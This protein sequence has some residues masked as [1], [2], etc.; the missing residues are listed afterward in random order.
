MT[1]PFVRYRYRG[2]REREAVWCDEH[3]MSVYADE[4]EEHVDDWH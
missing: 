4:W 2:G 3:V 1:E